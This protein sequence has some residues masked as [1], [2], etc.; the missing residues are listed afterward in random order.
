MDKNLSIIIDL[1]RKM[2]S[3]AQEGDL[4]CQDVGCRI[5]YSRLRDA[6]YELHHLAQKELYEHNTSELT[7]K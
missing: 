7:Q 6:S 4:S 1:C 2:R 3:L 5:V